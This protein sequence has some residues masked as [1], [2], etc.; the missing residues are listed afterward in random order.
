VFEKAV[1]AG[2]TARWHL[3]TCG[4]STFLKQEKRPTAAIE[5]GAVCIKC[6]RAATRKLPHDEALEP[7]GR[8]ITAAAARHLV[9]RQG[10]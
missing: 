3:G 7:H 9:N 6:A 10:W 4:W 8:V 2:E 5:P 1:R